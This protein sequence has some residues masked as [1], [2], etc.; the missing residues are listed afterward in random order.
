MPFLSRLLEVCPYAL[1]D[2]HNIDL[3]MQ[4]TGTIQKKNSGANKQVLDKLKVERER[5]ITGME[6]LCSLSMYAEAA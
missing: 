2:H 4:L 5:G 1:K 6:I 3:P